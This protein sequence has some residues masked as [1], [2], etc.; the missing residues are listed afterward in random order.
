MYVHIYVYIH[1]PWKQRVSYAM[2]TRARFFH[3]VY[4]YTYPCTCISTYMCHRSSVFPMIFILKHISYIAHACINVYAYAYIYIYLHVYIYVY[5]YVPW[6]KRFC[7]AIYSQTQFCRCT[8]MCIYLYIY[9]HVPCKMRVSYA[10]CTLWTQRESKHKIQTYLY[11]Y[12]WYLIKY[13]LYVL[14]D[15]IHWPDMPKYIY[16]YT[17]IHMYIHI[18]IHTCAMI[19]SVDPER[20]LSL[21][22]FA[23]IFYSP[24][25]RRWDSQYSS[26][27][28]PKFSMVIPC[29]FVE[30]W[31]SESFEIN[32][33]FDQRGFR[34][35]FRPTTISSL[36]F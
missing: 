35:A 12:S 26:E 33:D 15:F 3:C 20:D 30:L 7:Y 1:V 32:K 34:F 24:F 14:I 2:C 16:T 19:L 31:T 23:S 10:I 6:K 9:I 13:Q 18:H 21:W 25:P 22:P 4:I 27:C 29:L 5:T 17:Y 11:I 8:C 28:K 36:I